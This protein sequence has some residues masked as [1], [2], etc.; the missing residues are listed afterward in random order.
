MK[1]ADGNEHR[2][3]NGDPNQRV[4]S[5]TVARVGKLL[6]YSLGFDICSE[7]RQHL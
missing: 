2:L 5:W 7:V 4:S 3:P 6:Y 1:C